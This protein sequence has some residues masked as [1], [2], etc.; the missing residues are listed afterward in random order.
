MQ[1]GFVESLNGRLRDE[2]LNEHRIDP[3]SAGSAARLQS[4]SWRAGCRLSCRAHRQQRNM[5]SPRGMIVLPAR[6]EILVFSGSRRLLTSLG[7]DGN[8]TAA[9]HETR[10]RHSNANWKP[11]Q[12]FA[13]IHLKANERKSGQRAGL[14]MTGSRS[15]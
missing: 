8:S 4:Q 13:A 2:C 6:M 14:L 1:N 12:S 15:R 11:E 5:S 3:V 10:R 9:T 7:R